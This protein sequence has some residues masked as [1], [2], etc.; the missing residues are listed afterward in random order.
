MKRAHRLLAAGILLLPVWASGTTLYQTAAENPPAITSTDGPAST[1]PG[2][3]PDEQFRSLFATGQFEAALPFARRRIE[4]IESRPEPGDALASAYSDLG[5]TQL[6]IDDLD[7]A[8][9]SYLR[10]LELT[11]ANHSITDKR[12]VVPLAGLGATYAAKDQHD[13]AIECWKR[14]IN[15]SRRADGLFS[16]PQLELMNRLVASFEATGNQLGVLAERLTALRII[17]QNFGADDLRTLPAVTQIAELYESMD[18]YGFARGAYAHMYRISR[19]EGGPGDAVA[20]DALLGIARNHRLEFT[21]EPRSILEQA[22]YKDPVTGQSVPLM[23]IEPFQSPKPDREGR[24]AIT[25]ALSLLRATD[26]PPPRYLVAALLEMGDWLVAQGKHE[27]AM[28]YYAEAWSVSATELSEEP[29]PLAVPRLVFYRAPTASQRDPETTLG[30]IVTRTAVFRVLVDEAGIPRNIVPE[31][32][33][34]SSTQADYLRR[35][36]EK[37][38]YSPRFESGK[39]V[40]TTDVRFVGE[41]DLLDQGT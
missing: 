31:G 19:Q 21:R 9:A 18:E 20:I 25:E 5:A 23:S 13:L 39:P 3:D 30:K 10:A 1:D 29:N 37:A 16:L 17:E 12:L 34:V 27:K 8:E 33:E 41:W 35:S 4:L 36:L 14:A 11:E 7:G 2:Q 15:V 28:P 32:S 24:K 38:R 26:S 40:P 6:R 22:L